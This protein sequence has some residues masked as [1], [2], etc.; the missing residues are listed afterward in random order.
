M[1]GDNLHISNDLVIAGW[2]LVEQFTRASGPGGQHVNKT[3]SAVQLRWNVAAS[4]LPA[5]VKMRFNKR[6]GARLTKEGDLILEVKDHRSQ[7]LNREAA[8]K[9]LKEMVKSVAKPPKRRIA[10]KPTRG[11]VQRRIKA[12]KVR[13]EV[14]ALRG[15]VRDE[16]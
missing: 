1:A 5:A 6:Y 13:G 14:K 12:K 9:R 10:T 11:A 7:A 8:R 15:R 4:S 16:D 2:E 3:S